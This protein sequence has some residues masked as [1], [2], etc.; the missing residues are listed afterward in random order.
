MRLLAA[1]LV[2]VM[3]LAWNLMAAPVLA[4]TVSEVD[5]ET[6]LLQLDKAR[7]LYGRVKKS[8]LLPYTNE[9][10][11]GLPMQAKYKKTMTA[12]R[13]ATVMLSLVNN[14]AKGFNSVS[15]KLMLPEGTKFRK[16]GATGYGG[17][18]FAVEQEGTEVV[19]R[20]L[21]MKA[22]EKRLFQVQVLIL[23]G[24]PTPLEFRPYTTVGGEGWITG[25]VGTVRAL[26]VFIGLA[27]G[28]AI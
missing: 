15:V 1:L 4:A 21:Q 5:H 19:W 20:Q 22:G 11:C 9:S 7:E 27:W 8:Q 25:P 23:C 6:S 18:N 14:V 28:Q 2:A 17:K 16:A 24:A 3:A 13:K 10:I 26:Q 12:G